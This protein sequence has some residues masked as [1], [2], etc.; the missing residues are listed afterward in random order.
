[1]RLSRDGGRDVP[2][3]H[4]PGSSDREWLALHDLFLGAHRLTQSLTEAS[5]SQLDRKQVRKEARCLTRKPAS[6]PIDKG[7]RTKGEPPFYETRAG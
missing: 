6:P 1:M 5:K 4:V 7:K 2:R 3:D